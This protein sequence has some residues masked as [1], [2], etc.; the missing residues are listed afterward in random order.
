MASDTPATT[1][2][3]RRSLRPL[4]RLMP[5]LG[6]YKGLVAGALVSLV[7]AAV[8]TLTLPMGSSCR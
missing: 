8:T 5:Y 3:R 2:K 1:E 4:A 7:L 6:R